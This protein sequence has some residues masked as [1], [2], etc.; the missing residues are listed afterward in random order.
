M[1]TSKEAQRWQFVDAVA[2]GQWSVSELCARFGISRTTGYKWLARGGTAPTM[3][4]YDDQSRAPATCPHRTPVEIEQALLALRAKYGWGA[5]KLLHLLARRHVGTPLPARST[6]NAILD[7]HGVLRKNRRR[8]H[9]QHPGA[10]AVQTERPNQVWPADFKGQFKLQNGRYCYPLTITDHDSRK[11]L[12]CRAL[13]TIRTEDVMAAFRTLFRAVGLPDAIRTDN[14]A[15]FASRAIRG[16]TALSVW[17]LQLGIVHQRIHPGSPQENGQHERMH[18]DMKREATRPPAATQRGQQQKFDH[19]RRRYN[20]ERPHDALAGMVPSARWA[21]SPRPYP[22]RVRAPEYPGHVHRSAASAPFAS[23]STSPFSATRCA[24]SSSASKKSATAS[25]T[26]S[27]TPR[28]SERS[29][30]APAKSP[31]TYCKPCTWTFVRD[32][33]DRS[34]CQE[35]RFPALEIG[36]RM[37][38]AAG[39]RVGRRSLRRRARAASGRRHRASRPAQRRGRLRDRPCRSEGTP[40]H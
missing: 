1:E 13:P 20:D 6:V 39:R 35:K 38:P 5:K 34:Q 10:G 37:R 25:G 33:P 3:A 27:T 11:L 9:W 4:S 21:P 40:R 19:F 16:L 18:R 2:S 36:G 30:N 8:P 12:A 26:S 32:V 23:N 24:T 17:W 28:S 15:P 22:D 31:A 7:R 14:G 29:T